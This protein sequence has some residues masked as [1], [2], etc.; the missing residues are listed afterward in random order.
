MIFKKAKFYK[1]DEMARH[2][3]CAELLR[4]IY[5]SSLEKKEIPSLWETYLTLREWLELGPVAYTTL[6]ELADLYHFHLAK[7]SQFLKEHNLLP[8]IRRGDRAPKE[9]FGNCAIFLDN[10]RSAYNVGSILRTVEALRI[11]SVYFSKKTPGIDNPKVIKTS[12][13]ASSLVPCFYKQD[14][15]DLPRPF[16]ALDT[17]DKAEPIGSFLFPE[18]F[19]L[20]VGNEEYGIS[21]EVLSQVDTVVEI[22]LFGQKNSINA[23]CAFGIA[24]QQ[25]RNGKEALKI[26]S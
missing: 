19:T 20:I 7:A 3:K 8:P 14:L 25:I 24:A 11:G 10:L 1:L 13:G 5:V 16:I 12:M 18:S 17:G 15:K 4:L 2:K 23:A 6:K 21:D 26:T 22:P 9:P